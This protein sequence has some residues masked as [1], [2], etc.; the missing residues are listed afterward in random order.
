MA[1]LQQA[2]REQADIRDEM[3]ELMHRINENES[4][5]TKLSGK[6]GPANGRNQGQATTYGAP[7]PP[8]NGRNQ[9]QI[10]YGAPPAPASTYNSAMGNR[11]AEM[12]AD[13]A[14]SRPQAA[15]PQGSLQSAFAN[16][17]VL[18]PGQRRKKKP[19]LAELAAT[20]EELSQAAQNVAPID[21]WAEPGEK[22]STA[23]LDTLEKTL[24]QC[25]EKTKEFKKNPDNPVQALC[26]LF[27]RLDPNHS[28]KLD[29][30]EMTAMCHMLGFDADPKQMNSL[31]NR[32]DF[33]RSNT[34]D[35]SEFGK[36][37]FKTD[38]Q[39]KAISTIGRVRECL[40]IRAG[41]FATLKAMG[42]QFRIGDRD[43]SG[44]L[45]KEEFD[46]LL[47]ILLNAFKFKLAPAEKN[48]LFTFF[49]VDKS[50]GVSYDE[51]VREVRGPMNEAREQFVQMAFRTLDKDGSGV[52]DARDLAQ[53][54]DTSKCPNV[55]SRK[56][57]PQDC[58]NHFM[59]SLGGSKGKI[60]WE[61]FLEHYQWVSSNIDTDDYFEVMMRNAWHISGGKGW[62]ENT[63]DLRLLVTHF[64][65]REEVVE[66]QHDLG[67]PSDG[68]AREAEIMKR[69]GQQGVRDIKKLEMASAM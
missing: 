25:F 3:E 69:L 46:V 58:L 32:Y 41:G 19:T 60:T 56:T 67:L 16:R 51:F 30:N 50:G 13:I 42:S 4:L 37:M 11:Q 36:L 48:N 57:T 20:K 22:P 27:N 43:K 33:D 10:T 40:G 24:I 8:A 35:S 61:E 26:G 38:S 18:Q 15:Q 39:S 31:F 65:G 23:T 2:L 54:Y 49:D 34:I 6:Q 29:R 14:G 45:A 7:P 55:R 17:P 63:S 12:Q 1:G 59:E 5:I 68:K 28:G 21:H 47:D 62:C 53:A 64:N 66:L 44:Q 52:V 9:G